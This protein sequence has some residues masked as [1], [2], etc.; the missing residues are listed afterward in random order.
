MSYLKIVTLNCGL[1]DL[2]IMGLNIFSNPPY[3]NKR[4]KYIPNEL[5]KS[6]GDIIALQECFN[7]NY[8]K[9]IINKVQKIYKYS[10]MFNT[11]TLTQFS[12][13]LIILSK[14]PITEAKFKEYNLTNPIERIF[15]TKGYLTC[16]IDIPNIGLI[17]FINVHTTS[18]GDPPEENNNILTPNKL[19]LFNQLEEILSKVTI[20]TIIL[21]DFNCS[22]NNSTNNYNFLI[23]NNLIDVLDIFNKYTDL[24]LCTWKPNTLLTQN[25]PHSHYP[26]SCIDHIMI[27]KYLFNFCKITN[28]KIIFDDNIV[29]INDNMYS[30]ISDHF[31]IYVE[32]KFSNNT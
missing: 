25:G 14:Y 27:N 20:K 28:C 9:F 30:T 31:G 4:I 22:N 19:V 5:I 8:A 13:G 7:I 32:L 15:S 21:G 29:H 10:S 17:N 23:S 11:E 18:I 24:N 16:T 1:L 26:S 12:N 3:S 2:N 6:N